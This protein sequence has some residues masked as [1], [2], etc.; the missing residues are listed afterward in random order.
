MKRV[1]NSGSVSLLTLAGTEKELTDFTK[2][3]L[4]Q[5]FSKEN[6][7]SFD[8]VNFICTKWQWVLGNATLRFE[9]VGT[10][11]V[12]LTMQNA[13]I[14]RFSLLDS[15][16]SMMGYIPPDFYKKSEGLF[17]KMSDR[18]CNEL[19][20]RFTNYYDATINFYKK[21]LERGVCQEEARIVLPLGMFSTFCWEVDVEELL[22]FIRENY[23]K[24][25]EMYGYCH[26]FFAYIQE[27]FP[28]VAQWVQT[29]NPIF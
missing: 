23:N 28:L 8:A 18:D 7:S 6:M 9:I 27:N 16:S 20:T 26:V 1:L 15:A 24:S 22:S 11:D 25:P 13:H 17:I 19:T 14:G 2:S 5:T 12:F 29:N 21:L 3:S 10:F 4:E